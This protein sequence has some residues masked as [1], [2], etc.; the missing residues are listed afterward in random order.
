MVASYILSDSNRSLPYL[1]TQRRQEAEDNGSGREALFGSV[2]FSPSDPMKEI[3]SQQ[4]YVA[5]VPSGDRWRI[6][7]YR[8]MVERTNETTDE[9][10]L[11]DQTKETFLTLL[12]G[13]DRKITHALLRHVAESIINNSKH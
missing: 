1:N 8:C 3:Q 2:T 11:T 12:L 9:K 10:S 7:F 13:I 6:V 5:W 4:P